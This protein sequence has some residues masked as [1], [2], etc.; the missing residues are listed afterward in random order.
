MA[1]KVKYKIG[2]VF[3]VPL[4]ENFYGVGRVLKNSKATIFVELYR[5]KPIQN[6]D[7]YHFGNVSKE[8][9]IIRH[10][11]YDTGIRE[12]TWKIIDYQPVEGEIDMPFF[13]KQDAGDKKYYIRKGSNDSFHTIGERIE[14]PKA[15][16]HNYELNGIGNEVT[17]SSRYIKRLREAGL[18]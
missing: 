2:D 18:Y 7:E 10:W 17:E 8:P 14:I 5:M 9:P 4:E 11:C 3:L 12:G 6:A 16:I 15:D 13:W 1:R